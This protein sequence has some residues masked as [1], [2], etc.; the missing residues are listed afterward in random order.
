MR[1]GGSRMLI[2]LLVAAAAA[3]AV[4]PALLS[5]GH[6]VEIMRHEM[7]AVLEQCRAKYGEARTAVDTASADQWVPQTSGGARPGD[8]ACG[9]YRRRNMLAAES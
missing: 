2:L 6:K 7:V 3:A 9:R 5:R 8:P 4:V 1:R